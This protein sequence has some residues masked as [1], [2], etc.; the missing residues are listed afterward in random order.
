VVLLES[1]TIVS[2][3]RVWVSMSVLCTQIM[4]TWNLHV[5]M[6]YQH[7]HAYIMSMCNASVS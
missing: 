7:I 3:V 2:R 4:Y 1:S 5:C 6:H